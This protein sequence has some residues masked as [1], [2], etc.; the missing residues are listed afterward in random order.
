MQ[1][2]PKFQ[3]KPV[4]NSCL[5][6]GISPSSDLDM[7][8]MKGSAIAMSYRAHVL[9]REKGASTG[10]FTPFLLLQNTSRTAKTWMA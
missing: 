8:P 2:I 1:T 10:L 7:L 9:E 6:A 5:H 4:G 3:S